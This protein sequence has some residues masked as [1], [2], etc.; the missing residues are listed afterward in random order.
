MNYKA[1][2]I[3]DLHL[4]SKHSNIEVLLDFLKDNE[5]ESIYIV[6]D[7]I[8][9]WA[10]KRKFLWPKINNTLIQKLLRKSRHGSKVTW[11]LGN[12][13]DS[14]YDLIGT[15]FGG[16]DIKYDDIY[17]TKHNSIFTQ[18]YYVT[19]GQKYDGIVKY[20]PGIQK[21][22]AFLYDFILD[23]SYWRSRLFKSKW[24]I[25][26]AIKSNT[27]EALKY[28]NK[29]EECVLADLKENGYDGIIYGHLHQPSV[30]IIED[31][32][33]VNCGDFVEN[34]SLV[35]DDGK[36]FTLKYL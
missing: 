32:Q 33:F 3:S 23:L 36:C 13:E 19:H 15:N 34:I 16:I 12:H 4:G 6:G 20:T 30:S 22:G 18:R 1:L 10:L 7:F 31:K 21:L 5:F 9:C 17:E 25:A 35:V 14:L 29:F 28:I 24:S 11:I 8:D 26:K 2:F 27:K